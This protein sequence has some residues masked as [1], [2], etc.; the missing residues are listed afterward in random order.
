MKKLIRKS[1]LYGLM[2]LANVLLIGTTVSAQE[3]SV[4]KTGV[5]IGNMDVSGMTRQQTKDKIEAYIDELKDVV[6]TLV[7]ADE[8][9]FTITP[10]ELG[11]Q[12]S[13]TD[14]VEEA[15]QIGTSGNVI[16]R[17]KAIKDLE[18]DKKVYDLAFDYDIQAIN[19]LLAQEA[20]KYDRAA[21]DYSLARE[22]GEFKVVPGQ[23]GYATDVESSIDVVYDYLTTQWN[24]SPCEIQLDVAV[25]QPRGSEEELAQIQDVLGTYTTSF[26][27]SGAARS[28]NV[29]NGSDLI[30]GALLYPGDEFSTLD[31]I[32]PFTTANGY[33]MAGSY[34]NGKVVDSL[35]GGICQ[36]S[37]TLYNAVLLSEL[38]VT[39]RYNHSMI[40]TYVPPANDAAIA[41]SAGKDFKF[42]NTTEYPV[43][44]EGVIKNKRI[45]FNI[46]GKETRPE[47][48]VVT[49]KSEVLEVINPTTDNITADASKPLGYVAAEE[50]AHIGYRARLWKIV[51]EDGKEVSRTQVNTSKYKMTPRS[52]VVGVSTPDPNAYN[53]IMAAIGTGSI[54]HVKNVIALL[55]SAQQADSQHVVIG[56]I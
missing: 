56:D 21:V 11:I 28:Q 44:I 50:S 35:G 32:L 47:N 33:E 16:E 22:N 10:G 3:E 9:K 53:E 46:Y 36:V 26:A 23:A 49:Y 13:N 41:E 38:E 31:K 14:I 17:Y 54:D 25:T 45:T 2:L 1:G 52:A 51:T 48:R 7:A 8:N 4:I 12:W 40:V 42:I 20:V 5:Y 15:L 29:K 39:E 18:N 43:Y 55:Q 19:D 27:S 37:T 6:I 24:H 30:N 34:L